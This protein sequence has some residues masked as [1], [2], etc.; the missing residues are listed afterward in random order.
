MSRPV[1]SREP[2]LSIERPDQWKAIVSGPRAELIEFLLAIGPCSVFELAQHLDVAPDSLYHHVKKLVAAG[3]VREVGVQ[4]AGRQVE[5][6]YDVAAEDFDFHV[7]IESGA[8]LEPF[9]DLARTLLRRAERLLQRSFAARA[10]S[11]R[12]GSRDTHVRSSTAWLTR[13]QIDAVN[14]HL[15]AVRKIF[16]QGCRQREG[17]LHS[18]TVVMNPVV[19]TRSARSRKTGR[20]LEMEGREPGGADAPRQAGE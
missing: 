11:V 19:R 20:V 6:L 16:E 7:D 10:G 9:W 17:S 3:I 18:L 13:E 1:A 2:T 14:G 8:N 5:R 4:N 12:A 15:E